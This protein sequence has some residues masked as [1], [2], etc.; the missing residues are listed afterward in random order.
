MV[1]APQLRQSLKILQA[2]SMELRSTILE[3][4][5]INPTLEVM[6]SDEISLSDPNPQTESADNPE[7]DSSALGD[8]PSEVIPSDA[9]HDS[10]ENLDFS[11]DF[12]VLDRLGGDWSDVLSE[13]AGEIPYTSE[14][15]ERR[16]HFFDSL[17][18]VTSLQESLMDQARLAE[19]D[20]EVLG[21]LE[22]VIGSLD[23]SGFLATKASDL[24]LLAGCS[25]GSVQKAIRLLQSLEPVGIGAENV[26]HCL[27][28]QLRA[29][30]QG[31]SLAS[32]IIEKEWQRLLRRRIP[33]ISRSLRVSPTDVQTAL[34]IISKLDPAPGKQFASDTNQIIEP[35]VIVEKDDEGVWQVILT[36]EYIPRLRLSSE[37]KQ[38]LA[39]GKLRGKDR[40][41]L[42]DKFRSSR[43]LISAIEQRQ[44]T[45]E[46]ITRQLLEFQADFFERGSSQLKPLTMNQVAEVV[47][48]HETTVS[49]AIANKFIRTPFG[50][51]EMKYF[52]TP[53]YT[54]SD[55]ATVSNKSVKERIA[56]II[57]SE[58][59]AKPFSDQKIVE[60]LKE[61]GFSIARRTVAKYRE[62]LGIL[63][64]NLRRQYA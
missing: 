33:E 29:K 62:E 41:Y 22:T 43:F 58:P 49:R 44:N 15:A 1:L 6:A 31:R 10:A 7:A 42:K 51:F 9:N 52:F 18:G 26:Q 37:Y 59:A 50:I 20:P 45:I 5:E 28:L 38:I 36:N 14:D 30:G 64:T 40:E 47:G 46:R 8:D 11:D 23:D 24:A 3:E 55:G 63:P 57:E 19:S 56:R 32:R 2:A 4:M 53:G 13:N 48:V 54:N 25:L 21:A 12:S 16:Q 34:E 61:E 27:L 60:L 35:D 39:S 17:T